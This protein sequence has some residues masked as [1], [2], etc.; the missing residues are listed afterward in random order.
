[1]LRKLLKLCIPLMLIAML[2]GTE[3]MAGGLALSG[4]GSRAISM[5]GAFRGL[6][7]DW[8]ACYWN[9]AGLATLEQSEVGGMITIIS[10][11]PEYTPDIK[12]GENDVL[13]YRNGDKRYT[14]DQ[15]HIIPG[16]SGFFK[17]PDL[18]GWT[19]GMGIFVPYG[20]GARWDIFDLP[21]GFNDQPPAN[22]QV[23]YPEIDH[24]SE[25]SVIDFHPTVA[26]EL[27]EGQLSFGLGLS[28]QK[29]TIT[30]QQLIWAQSDTTFPVPYNFLFTDL[31]LEGDGWAIGG[32]AGL[33]YK[34]NDKFQV[35]LAYR[36]PTTLKLKGTARTDVY[37]P[38]NEEIVELLQARGTAADTALANLLFRGRVLTAK[39]NA[40]ADVKLPADYGIGFAYNLNEKITITADVNYTAWSRLDVVPLVLSG[41][42]PLGGSAE[43]DTLFLEWESTTRFSL[44]ME[45]RHSEKLAFRAGFFNDP[46]PI[47]DKTFSPTIPDMGGKNSFNF[48]VGYDLGTLRIDYNFEFIKFSERSIPS[49][50][51]QDVNNDGKYDNHPG[52]YNQNLYANF[53][54]ITHRF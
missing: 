36:S 9:P 19:V 24:K 40:E 17:V 16:L 46:S 4:V 47:P 27:I 25:F 11:K 50:A 45:Y 28:I 34:L 21:A 31:E 20:T 13:G 26:K 1:M 53:I 42:S 12:L 2:L 6:A 41:A 10:P 44:G 51:Y 30:L 14:D 29:G 37:T 48:G 54:S 7:N 43:D 15:D 32:N 52:I 33:L 5:G 3:A 35:G 18:V 38:Y 22:N 49:S 8:S 39:P 23:T